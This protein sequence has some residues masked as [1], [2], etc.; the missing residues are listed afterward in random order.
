[1]AYARGFLAAAPQRL[2]FAAVHPSGFYGRIP[3][4]SV[5]RFLDA[6]EERWDHQGFASVWEMRRFAM[7]TLTALRPRIHQR[8]PD[9]PR[10]FYVQASPNNLTKP[11]LVASILK[12]ERARFVCLVHDLIPLQYP[13]Y[14]RPGGAAEHN[15]RIRTILDYADGVIANSQATLEALQP[16]MHI[17]GREPATVVAHLGTHLHQQANSPRRPNARPYFVCIGTIE[18]RKNHL[19]LLNLW[20]RMAE[21]YGA[22]AIPR[23]II[24]GR[25]GW[26][27][28]QVVDMLER[29][30]AL[31]DC[32][33]EEGRLSD[34]EVAA[35]LP[36]ACALLMPSF[37]EGY[38]MPIAEALSLGV[39]VICS[40]LPVFREAGSGI[41]E[42]L[43]PLD[44]MGW[45]R[46]VSDYAQPDGKDR[47]AQ[48]E[49][50]KRWAAPTWPQHIAIALKLL[51]RTRA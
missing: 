34:R 5:L 11:D 37:A 36:G 33:E 19:L 47:M 49:R 8:A 13:E 32:V 48:L 21:E 26:E 20:R 29:C 16:W 41:P 23:L 9:A 24:I 1:M 39:P 43:D 6:T 10:P 50:L 28:E 15:V 46:A 35:L 44:G 2:R 4:A 40:D 25:R 42:Y 18:P 22:L 30:P 17:V 14:A 7:S 31:K 38:G 51:H 3:S 45:L 27:N 12:R